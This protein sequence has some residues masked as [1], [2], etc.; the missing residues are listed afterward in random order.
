MR[1]SYT[2][3]RRSGLTLPK[4]KKSPL[5]VIVIAMA[6]GLAMIPIYH[7]TKVAADEQP[8][9]QVISP[10]ASTVN[11]GVITLSF[12]VDG[13]STDQYE[14]FWSVG[15]DQWNRMGTTNG[16]STT[17]VDVTNWNWNAN[18]EYTF[19]F[20]ALKKENWQPIIEKRT[21][22]I[23]QEGTEAVTTEPTPTTPTQVPAGSVVHCMLT[24][25]RVLKQKR[26]LGLCLTLKIVA[27]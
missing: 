24:Q 16:V 23:N 22:T 27:Q 12:K 8:V 20:I 9:V 15:N 25:S 5:K 10:I 21:V 14:P 1:E 17:E 7:A 4:T 26:K 18:N 13:L 11:R 3:Q 2:T 6:A 19:S